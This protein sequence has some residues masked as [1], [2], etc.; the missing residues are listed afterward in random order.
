MKLTDWLFARRRNAEARA[1]LY[2]D[3]LGDERAAKESALRNCGR[4]VVQLEAKDRE[5]AALRSQLAARQPEQAS[6]ALLREELA[7]QKRV[8]DRLSNQLLDATG[9]N[10]APLTAAAR[11]KLGLP[12]QVKP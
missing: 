6:I 10:G 2:G 7:K 5:I 4:L 3:W 8:N 1:S 9:H 12:A 11:E